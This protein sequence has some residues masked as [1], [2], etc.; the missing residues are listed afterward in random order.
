MSRI[1]SA[2]CAPLSINDWAQLA[3]ECC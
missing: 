3:A 2:Q 1:Y